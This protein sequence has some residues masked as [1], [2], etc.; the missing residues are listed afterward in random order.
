MDPCRL[1][2]ALGPVAI[3]LT[4]IGLINT[5]RRPFL[6]SGTR[7]AAALGLAVSGLM[8][9]GPVELF[10]PVAASLFFGSFVWVLL[11]ALYALC[12][13]L[14]LLL[15]RPRIVV[16][17]VTS[18]ELRPI[19]TDVA[20]GLDPEARWAGDSLVLPA[21]RIQLHVECSPEMR[22][23]SLVATGPNQSQQ[24]WGRLEVALRDAVCRLKV[25]CKPLAGILV[26]MGAVL[27]VIIAQVIAGDP[28]AVA[29]SLFDMLRP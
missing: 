26:G 15:L 14:V 10:F 19:L 21:L 1:C 17:N 13:T 8:I 3:Y 11:I 4:L 22:N 9:V 2:L 16:Y 27:L 29:Q 6:V 23:V 12:L 7:D 24:G 5:F 18:N 28:R 25:P 20:T